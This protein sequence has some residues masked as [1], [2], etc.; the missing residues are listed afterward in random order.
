MATS[1]GSQQLS[2]QD[3]V[4]LAVQNF[5]RGEF[6]AV[7]YLCTQIL[8]KVP[9]H[10]IALQLKGLADAKLG[11]TETAL[12]TLRA[13]VQAAPQSFEIRA[14]T[15]ETFRQA[16]QVEEALRIG[17]EGLKFAQP[18]VTFLANLGI[19]HYD[20]GDL[21]RAKELHAQA[22]ELAPKHVASLNNLGS[23]ARDERDP[24]TAIFYYKR[25]LEVQPQYAESMA[26]LATLYIEQDDLAEAQATLATLFSVDAN[27]AEGLRC[28][29]R[30]HLARS[31]LDAAERAFKRAIDHSPDELRNYTNL[32]QVMIEK[33]QP[34]IARDMAAKAL[35][36]DASSDLALHQMGIAVSKLGSTDEAAEWYRK[37]IAQ[38]PDFS[39]SIQGLAQLALEHGESET[40][41]EYFERALEIEPADTGAL[42]GLSRVSK[43]KENDN[44]IFQALEELLPMASE[45]SVLRQVAYRFAMGDIYDGLKRYDEAF[46]QYSQ[47]ARL[48]RGTISYDADAYDQ[49]ISDIIATFTPDFIE[50]LKPHANPS[51]RPIFVLGMPRSG[52]TM[53]ETILASHSTVSGAGELSD[54]Q[55]L[56]GMEA[57]ISFPANLR[58]IT[59]ADMAQRLETYLQKLVSVDATSAHVTD[60]MPANFHMLG[61]IHALY[62]NA[63]IVHTRRNAMDVC[64][65]CFTRHFDRSQLQSYDLVEQ[66]RFFLG[67]KRLMA[68]W[69]AVLPE[70]AFLTV[71]YEQMVA[72]PEA[73]IRRL[74]AHCD[75]PWEDAC[76]NF[77][78]TKRRVKT[79][80]IT[81]VRQPIYKSS[82]EKWR[83]YESHLGPLIETLQSQG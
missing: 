49:K 81:Q 40:A 22:L 38:T 15:I 48:K 16:G 78:K 60:K 10:P 11:N 6:K 36:M 59:A 23:I 61:L 30:I 62:P 44:P 4:A 53:T 77:H 69:E 67:Y 8:S 12:D 64:L 56:F 58:N 1:S 3:A 18:T 73:N 33:N 42:V 28:Q 63:K 25:V 21:D 72:D 34:E 65:S 13:A 37:A 82:V 31:E 39:P 20:A 79:A 41:R 68:H 57:Q 24:E 52:T 35:S 32:S 76:L 71:D 47:A 5:Q 50:A 17:D 83:R 43:I 66:G 70:G 19:A 54:L 51:A 55:Q 80:S 26:N 2:L 46:A 27:H 9:Q 7:A 14:N 75:L 74:L 29:G 45:M